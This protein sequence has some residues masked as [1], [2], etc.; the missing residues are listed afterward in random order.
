MKSYL[1]MLIAAILALAT[2]GTAQAD[3]YDDKARAHAQRMQAIEAVRAHNESVVKIGT[4]NSAITKRIP[5]NASNVRCFDQHAS[6]FD[7]CR[8]YDSQWNGILVK[9]CAEAAAYRHADEKALPPAIGKC[10]Y[11]LPDGRDCQIYRNPNF[12]PTCY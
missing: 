9:I 6:L 2:L 11:T 12:A 10:R 8:L 3:P 5:R 1:L 7:N 4:F